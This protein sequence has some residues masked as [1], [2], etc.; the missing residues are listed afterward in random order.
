MALYHFSVNQISRG[1]GQSAMAAASYR[2]GEKLYCDYYGQSFDYTNKHGVVFKEILLPNHAPKELND[3]QTLWNSLEH[4][5]KNP[6]A[7][8]AYSFDIALQNELSLDENIQLARAFVLQNFVAKGMIADMAVHVPDKDEGET[9]NPHFHVM[10]PIRPLNND[11]SWGAKQHREYQLDEN[12][13]RLKDK[14]DNYIFN[15]VANT[16]WGTP[17][18]LELWRSNWAKMVNDIFEQ[19]GL[20]C[21]ID[22]R[23]YE[24]QGLD[25]IPTI[26][27]GPTVRAMEKKGKKTFKRDFNNWV[28][29]TTNFIKELKDSIEGIISWC[30]QLKE[31]IDELRYVE[32]TVVDMVNGYYDDRNLSAYTQKIKLE[33]AKKSI[34]DMIFL[35]DND[36]LYL[37]D[38]KEVAQ[39][40]KDQLSELDKNLSSLKNQIK[41][42]KDLI[43]RGEDYSKFAETY[44][45]YKKIESVP[46]IGEQY[47]KAHHNEIAR[48]KTAVRIIKEKANGKC[49][50][51]V[52]KAELKEL[53]LQHENLFGEYNAL[54]EKDTKLNHIMYC[55][56]QY[57]EPKSNP[58]AL[59]HRESVKEKLEKYRADSVNTISPTTKNKRKDYER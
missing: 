48:Y 14:N 26:H 35:K 2:S 11:G 38:L 21:R 12:G 32:P 33:N 9:E 44:K 27:E 28:K 49:T 22:S 59:P 47:E 19:K 42:K 8:L 5:E 45:A 15:A 25:T 54:K 20:D 55:V 51:D 40:T 6:K 36:I 24:R 1:K 7:Q 43:R 29:C 58:N 34:A 4:F 52:W 17:D 46:F 30:I 13:E 57:F 31:I 37:S 16:D 39:A 56:N 23:S 3:R 50:T 53:E 10:C 18:T 41:S